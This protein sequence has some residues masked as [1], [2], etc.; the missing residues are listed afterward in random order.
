MAKK[1]NKENAVCQTSLDFDQNNKAFIY[2]CNEKPPTETSKEKNSTSK[3]I[4]FDTRQ[5]IYRKIL[6]RQMK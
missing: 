3:I 2:S 1:N 6:D 4:Y 5:E